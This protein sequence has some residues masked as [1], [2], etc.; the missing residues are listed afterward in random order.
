MLVCFDYDDYEKVR[1][2]TI[3]CEDLYNRLKCMYQGSKNVKEY[4]G[5]IEVAL[6]RANVLESNEATMAHFLHGLNRDI[7]DI[8]ELYHYAPM[9]DLVH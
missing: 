8:V 4:H 1:V 2:V 7:Q 5:D 3:L 9:D 6:M